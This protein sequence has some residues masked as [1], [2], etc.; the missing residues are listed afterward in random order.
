MKEI[1]EIVEKLRGI[2][3][4]ERAILATVVDVVGSGYRRP[5]ARML[6]GADG[7][8]LGTV[9]GGCL[10]ADVLERATNVLTSGKPE[11]ITYDTTRDENSVFG[12]SMGCRGVIRILLQTVSG[13]DEF[14]AGVATAFASRRHFETAV[15]IGTSSASFMLGQRIQSDQ[16]VAAGL[17]VSGVKPTFS[18]SRIVST[19]AAEFF[20]ETI[21]PPV[22]LVVFGGGFDAPPVARFARQLGWTVAVVDHRPAFL[23]SERFPDSELFAGSADDLPAD[24]FADENS[25]AV[26]MTHN[27][28]RDLRL[29][30]RI[31]HAPFKYVGALGPKKRTEKILA[32]AAIDEFPRLHAP[33]G[34]DIGGD[35]PETIALAVIAEIHAALKNRPAGFLRDRDGSIYERR[36]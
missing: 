36:D 24:F 31:L 29:L 33:V 3:P 32:D 35:S 17:A 6:I 2:E 15:V 11:I 23:T 10:E 8:A 21:A 5:G 20:V 19:E 9:S 1:A 25:V 13:D 12:L 4:G 7:R 26:V 27:Y 18:E 30:P 22:R 16:F 28:D 34:L 14:L